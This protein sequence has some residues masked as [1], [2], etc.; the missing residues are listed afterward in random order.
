MTPET[1]SIISSVV[2][3]ILAFFAVA[4]SIWFFLVGRNTEKDVSNSLT[5]IKTQTEMLQKISGKQLDRLTK[6]V[7]EPKNVSQS[8]S[9]NEIL[10]VVAQ[11]PI[12]LSSTF[13]QNSNSADTAVLRAELISCYIALYFYTA[14]TNFW[15]HINLPDAGDFDAENHFDATC[16]RITDMSSTDFAYMANILVKFDAGELSSNPLNHLLE[17]TK[18]NW[19]NFVLNTAQVYEQRAGEE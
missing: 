11:I 16:K 5:E 14:Q 17:E 13:Q 6:Y 18:E 8:E 2:S 15:S 4:I 3:V 12:S 7:T 10:K 1:W 19:R 9:F